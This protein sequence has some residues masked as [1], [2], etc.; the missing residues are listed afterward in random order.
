[1]SNEL[2]K[3][4]KDTANDAGVALGRLF[5]HPAILLW[6]TPTFIYLFPALAPLSALGYWQWFGLYIL[7]NWVS[8]SLYKIIHG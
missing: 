3:Q 7:F 8:N 1:M 4:V 5:L 2:K 6:M